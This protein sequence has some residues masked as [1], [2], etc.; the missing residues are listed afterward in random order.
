MNK[1][2]A[3]LTRVYVPPLLLMVAASSLGVV[4]FAVVMGMV[5][6]AAVY[7][8]P[9]EGLYYLDFGWHNLAMVL[10]IILGFFLSFA[11]GC[12][13]SILNAL[14]RDTW[15][16][17]RYALSFWMLATPIVYPMQAIPEQYRSIAYLNPLAPIIEVFRWGVL[18]YG[19]VHWGFVAVAAGEI[20]V[21]L[22][23][24]IWFFGK[25]QNRFFDHM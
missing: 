10:A 23:V 5:A 3:V 12:F 17:M 2:S 7:Y 8:G 15:L 9:I 14:A 6:V 13:T 19:T 21:L 25:Q 16:T 4:E 18:H 11:I 24:G 20:L 1:N 22:L